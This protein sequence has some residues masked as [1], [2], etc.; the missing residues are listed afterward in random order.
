M[1]FKSNLLLYLLYYAEACNKFAGPISA[2]LCAGNTA[3]FEEMLQRWQA[4]S[5]TVSD[6]TSPRFELQTSRST[7]E[8]VTARPT[9]RYPWN[10]N[11]GIHLIHGNPC[12][13]T[14]LFT[15]VTEHSTINSAEADI[16]QIERGPSQFR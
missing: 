13:K 14:Y 15:K 16:L 12:N 7:N 10:Y 5:N 1:E 2:S 11:P 3:P 9:G 4:V 8:R 6:L